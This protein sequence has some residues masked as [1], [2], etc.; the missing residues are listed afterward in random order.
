MVT[1]DHKIIID[2][3]TEKSTKQKP[4][5]PSSR[6][7][8][9][10]AAA[11]AVVTLKVGCLAVIPTQKFNGNQKGRKKETG[12]GLANVPKRPTRCQLTL[13]CF[14]FLCECVCVWRQNVLRVTHICNQTSSVSSHHFIISLARVWTL[15]SHYK[16]S[17]LSP[18]PRCQGLQAGRSYQTSLKQTFQVI[19]KYCHPLA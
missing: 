11:V 1:S 15:W 8:R 4:K 13:K 7:S 19:H 14:L 17:L 6:R 3:M 10:V 2:V 12:M 9:T 16:L 18:L 5:V